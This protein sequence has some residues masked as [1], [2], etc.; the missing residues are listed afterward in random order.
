MSLSPIARRIA[1]A[2]LFGSTAGA[3]VNR[4]SKEDAV[5]TWLCEWGTDGLMEAIACD[6]EVK[7][8]ACVMSCFSLACV[9]CVRNGCHYLKNNGP[10]M[11][12]LLVTPRLAMVRQNYVALR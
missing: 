7:E 8:I 11:Q 10:R 12:A 1:V 5:R 3:S 9:K 4:V 6:V 2:D